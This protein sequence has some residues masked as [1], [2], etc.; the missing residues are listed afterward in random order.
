MSSLV[1][2]RPQ[3]KSSI[4]VST[5]KKETEFRKKLTT[6]LAEDKGEKVLT[7]LKKERFNVPKLVNRAN[8][9]AP[10]FWEVLQIVTVYISISLAVKSLPSTTDRWTWT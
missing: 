5:R 6:R 10:M 7:D 3:A 9:A 4:L 2:R 8:L 1:A